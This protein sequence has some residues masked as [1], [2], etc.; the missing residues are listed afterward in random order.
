MRPNYC[1]CALPCGGG[2]V[3][4]CGGLEPCGGVELVPAGGVV[5]CG[6]VG[7]P[8]GS[9]RPKEALLPA[10]SSV[11]SPPFPEAACSSL[12]HL[13][14]LVGRSALAPLAARRSGSPVP[15][16]KPAPTSAESAPCLPRHTPAGMECTAAASRRCAS[17]QNPCPSPE[18]P[19]AGHREEIGWPPGWSFDE[20]N[21]VP[22]T[23]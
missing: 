22:S 18:L 7:V 14:R 15:H 1:G 21:F 3:V 5:P 12:A 6:G 9:S 10:E 11:A 2:V 4:P 20:S 17:L 19:D 16:R 8:G 13:A 23:R